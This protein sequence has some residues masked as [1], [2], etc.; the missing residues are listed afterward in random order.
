MSS[1]E[2]LGK[3]P[4]NWKVRMSRSGKGWALTLSKLDNAGFRV[5]KKF[6]NVDVV[7]LVAEAITFAKQS[8]KLSKPIIT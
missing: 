5:S 2:A 6:K 7:E 4:S 3:I 1:L 8:D